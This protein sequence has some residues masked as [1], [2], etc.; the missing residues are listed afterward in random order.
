MHA[1]RSLAVFSGLALSLC[2]NHAAAS[3]PEEWPVRIERQ[4]HAYVVEADGRYVETVETAIKVLKSSG[5]SFAKDGSIGYSTS[6]QQA[7]VLEAYTLKPDGRRIVV[8]PG[9]FQVS[10]NQGRAGDSPIYSDRSSLTVVFPELAVGD[11]TVLRYRLT[12]KAA[13]FDGHFSVIDSFSPARYYGDVKIVIDAPA[14]LRASHQAWQLK[15][16]RNGVEGGRRVLEWSWQNREPVDEDTLRDRT[17]DVERYPGYAFSTFAGYADIAQAYGARADA[18]AAVTPRID[19]LAKELAG[20]ASEPREV[21]KRLYDFVSREISYAGNCIGLGAV[22][23]RDLDVVLDNRMGDCKDHATLLQA[24]LKARG[25][26]STQALVNAGDVHVLPKTP[27]ASM[28]NHVITYVPSL[29]LYMD[30]TSSTEPFGSLPASVAGKRVLLVRG[31]RDDTATPMPQRG[32]NSQR[33]R[34]RMAIAEDGSVQGDVNMH[35]NGRVAVAVRESF[36]EAGDRVRKDMVRDYFRSSGMIADGTVRVEAPDAM[37]EQITLDV[38]YKV[39]DMVVLPGGFMVSPWFMNPMAISSIVS[40]QLPDPVRPAGE[41]NCGGTRSEES[42]EYTLAPSLRI[43]AVPP[44][45]SLSEGPVSYTA[46]HRLEGQRLIVER[47][48]DDRT[49]GPVCTAEYNAAYGR[50]MAQIMKNLRAQVVI[51]RADQAAR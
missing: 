23:P 47:T 46:R 5:L 34:A 39:D 30:S 1:F 12:A 6:I 3:D 50:L 48:L 14:S 8:P 19:A 21:A 20:D 38:D 45:V 33:M 40:A 7:D 43:A 51:L 27:V 22:V 15:E 44:D 32:N 49:P 29:D 17:F 37:P 4:H 24:L 35:I 11:T 16:V 2:S 9:N 28:V 36:R 13:M 10:S 18:K 42:Y 31:Y 41:T 26:D 25:I